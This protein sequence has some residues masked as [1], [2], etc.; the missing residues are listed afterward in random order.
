MRAYRFVNELGE[1]AGQAGRAIATAADVTSA[2][3]GGLTADEAAV[4]SRVG[5]ELV[6][7]LARETADRDL[8]Q[9]TFDARS[10]R[11]GGETSADWPGV[12][13]GLVIRIDLPT[14]QATNIVLGSTVQR[15]TLREEGGATEEPIR[16]RVSALADRS[17]AAYL[18]LV[19]DTETRVIPAQSLL[20]MA[21]PVSQTAIDTH[22]YG[23]S[24]GRFVEEFVEGFVGTEQLEADPKPIEVSPTDERTLRNWGQR[25][26]LRGV[27][28]LSVT[29]TEDRIPSSLAAFLD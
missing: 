27:Y 25:H 1:A 2:H 22:L 8:S 11:I 24:F 15:A 23:R 16:Q 6:R 12:D 7:Q 21:D 28:S 18:F 3:Q 13:I 14:Y 5:A 19:T 26:D 29:A 10:V 4:E 20:A 17:P 9:V